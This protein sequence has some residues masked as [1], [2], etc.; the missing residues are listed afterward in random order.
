MSKL[1]LGQDCYPKRIVLDG[2][3]VF[4]ESTYQFKRT[5]QLL[6][7][8]QMYYVLHINLRSQI[9][10]LEVVVKLL[11]E[12][13]RLDRKRSLNLESQIRALNEL[14]ENDKLAWRKTTR[15]KTRKAFLVGGGVAIAALTVLTLIF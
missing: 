3:T 10:D 7:A 13:D 11:E 5:N 6:L 15:K 8:G 12:Q 4:V 1:S 2:D 14:H 9:N